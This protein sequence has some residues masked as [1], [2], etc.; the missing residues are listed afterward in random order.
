ME[1]ANCMPCLDSLYIGH[2]RSNL[3]NWLSLRK[4]MKYSR[5][6]E[7]DHVLID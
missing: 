6:T 2:S 4:H 3:H 1:K 7:D 5:I